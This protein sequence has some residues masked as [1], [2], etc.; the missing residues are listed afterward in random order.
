MA[1]EFSEEITRL[2]GESKMPSSD[3]KKLKKSEDDN[4]GNQHKENKPVTRNIDYSNLDKKPTA[5]IGS[6]SGEV[7]D[8][9]EKYFSAYH[10]Q[11]DHKQMLEAIEPTTSPGSLTCCICSD[12]FDAGDTVACGGDDIHFFCKS[13]L[14]SY[15]H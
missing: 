2:E 6:L 1:K 13:C 11:K 12:D 3:K 7:L 4:N 14:S 10:A 8:T 9:L 5:A 15:A